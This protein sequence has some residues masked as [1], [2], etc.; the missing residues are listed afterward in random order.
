VGQTNTELRSTPYIVSESPKL[1]HEVKEGTAN[2]FPFES[3]GLPLF[4]R[5]RANSG[6]VIGPTRHHGG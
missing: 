2:A 6:T 3:D 5:K 1:K 4:L